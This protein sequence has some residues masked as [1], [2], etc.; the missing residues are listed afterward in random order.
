MVTVSTLNDYL[1]RWYGASIGKG[2]RDAIVSDFAND[3]DVATLRQE[4]IK[5]WRKPNDPVLMRDH[6]SRIHNDFLERVKNA[7]PD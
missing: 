2:N 7:R 5:R 6:I 3:P 4:A 1:S